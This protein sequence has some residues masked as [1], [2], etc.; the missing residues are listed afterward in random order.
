RAISA[1]AAPWFA[2]MRHRL[3]RAG[4]KYND[5]TYGLFDTGAMVEERVVR[6]VAALPPGVG[7]IYFHPATRRTPTLDRRMPHY[8]HE[9]EFA[10]L[11][12]PRLRATLAAHDI[13][14]IAFRDL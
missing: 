12:S 10:A 14:P 5:F 2:V 13:K 4:M 9:E 8:R 7:E 1:V 6:Q 11:T 3:R